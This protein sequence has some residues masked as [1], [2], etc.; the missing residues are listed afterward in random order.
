VES[1]SER[2]GTSHR[3]EKV[4]PFVKIHQR[5]S[6]YQADIYSL[7]SMAKSRRENRHPLMLEAVFAL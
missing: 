6:I 7:S 3:T 4:D 1:R 5:Y 2:W